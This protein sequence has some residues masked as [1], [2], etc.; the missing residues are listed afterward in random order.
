MWIKKYI[1]CSR[2]VID[3]KILKQRKYKIL[4]SFIA[5]LIIFFEL[6]NYYYQTFQIS[7]ISN[8][9]LIVLGVLIWILLWFLKKEKL[10]SFGK[11]IV[12]YFFILVSVGW[13]L[14]FIAEIFF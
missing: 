2:G 10:S 4:L 9:Y 12:N 3:M 7:W 6:L 1:K 11:I 8:T 5:I 14:S 13:P